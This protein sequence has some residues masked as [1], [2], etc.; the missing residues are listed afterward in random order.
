MHI[1]RY[2]KC[3]VVA[4]PPASGFRSGE[5]LDHNRWGLFRPLHVGFTIM[6]ESGYLRAFWDPKR[7]GHCRGKS[8]MGT[9]RVENV[10]RYY[11]ALIKKIIFIK[12]KFVFVGILYFRFIIETFYMRKFPIQITSD[13]TVATFSE[14]KIANIS[15]NHI[16]HNAS[17]K[18]IFSSDVR[19]CMDLCKSS[20]HSPRWVYNMF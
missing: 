5:G 12:T 19:I 13:N 14:N 20:M 16:R 11:I 6:P 18:R 9:G 17:K 4:A 8:H 10:T 3:E 2:R 15:I 1:L 7:S